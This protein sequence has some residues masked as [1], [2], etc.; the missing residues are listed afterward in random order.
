MPW[1]VYSHQDVQAQEK[2]WTLHEVAYQRE[3]KTERPTTSAIVAARG[4]RGESDGSVETPIQVVQKL[5]L[6]EALGWPDATASLDIEKLDASL[7]VLKCKPTCWRVYFAVEV[8]Q[9]LFILADAVCKKKW[10]RNPNDRKTASKRLHDWHTGR[11]RIER[12]RVPPRP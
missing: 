3:G 9:R 8:A 10:K 11:A 7:F 4:G 6:L 5:T 2:H 1:K 12:V